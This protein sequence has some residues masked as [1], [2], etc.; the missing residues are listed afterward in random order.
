MRLLDLRLQLHHLAGLGQRLGLVHLWR[1]QELREL[2][3]G[4]LELPLEPG[5][6]SLRALELLEDGLALAV[7]EPQ[8][9]LMGHDQLGREELAPDRVGGR[10]AG[11]LGAGR[12]GER[13]ARQENPESATGHGTPRRGAGGGLSMGSAAGS[14]VGSARRVTRSGVSSRKS[15]GP[16][17][18]VP[19]GRH[20]A[21]G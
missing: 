8:L 17:H 19:V 9:G 12:K 16:I 3:A 6:L 4:G 10:G 18:R 2:L 1:I 11:A 7:I 20:A 21:G 13:K 15:V 5:E 14:R